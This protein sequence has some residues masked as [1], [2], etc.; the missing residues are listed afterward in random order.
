MRKIHQC[1]GWMCVADAY[2]RSPR[3]CRL[4]LSSSRKS[5]IALY[6][7]NWCT[8]LGR[9]ALSRSLSVLCLFLLYR[10]QFTVCHNEEAL[11]TTSRN[12]CR[13]S[14]H[15][16]WERRCCSSIFHFPCVTRALTAAAWF[17]REFCFSISLFG[18]HSLPL[19][20]STLTPVIARVNEADIFEIH[21]KF[22]NF[23]SFSCLRY[24]YSNHHFACTMPMLH[25]KMPCMSTGAAYVNTLCWRQFWQTTKCSVIIVKC[26]KFFFFFSL[27]CLRLI[28]FLPLYLSPSIGVRFSVGYYWTASSINS[29]EILFLF[30]L[31]SAVMGESIACEPSIN[32]MRTRSILAAFW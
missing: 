12:H 4:L 11:H 1:A 31:H 24:F 18:T 14:N 5:Y 7:T 30:S 26:N 27:Q 19:S 25:N 9:P 21:N 32:W 29:K 8:P 6:I 15:A 16:V 13:R 20:L 28:Y 22:S 10:T 2:S 17:V 23:I 3:G